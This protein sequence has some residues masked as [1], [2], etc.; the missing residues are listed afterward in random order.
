MVSNEAYLDLF[1]SLQEKI[2][3]SEHNLCLPFAIMIQKLS[4]NTW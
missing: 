2:V 1:H 3:V 4:P